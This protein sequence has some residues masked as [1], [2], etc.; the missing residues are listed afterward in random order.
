MQVQCGFQSEVVE[1]LQAV[2]RVREQLLLPSVAGPSDAL[3]ILVFWGIAP[4]ERPCL[5]PVHIQNHDIYRD[6]QGAYFLAESHKL[7]VRVLPESAP[8]VSE[9]VFRRK[10]NL[11]AD[12]HEIL[13]CSLVVVSICENVEVFPL[14]AVPACHPVLPVSVLRNENLSVGFVDDGPAVA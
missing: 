3:A 7:E 1:V 14:N 10:R 8:P 13:D 12:L 4:S 2:R 5:V 6:A 11:S 9:R